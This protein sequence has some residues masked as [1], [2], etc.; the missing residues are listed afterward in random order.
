MAAALDQAAFF[1]AARLKLSLKNTD[2]GLRVMRGAQAVS[3]KRLERIGFVRFTPRLEAGSRVLI[4][5]AGPSATATAVAAVRGDFDATITLNA[6]WKAAPGAEVISYEFAFRDATKYALQMQ[7]IQMLD[8]T[9][10]VFKPHALMMMPRGERAALASRFLDVAVGNA[11]HFVPHNNVSSTYQAT[12]LG[13]LN[14]RRARLPIQWKGSLTMWL[15]LCWL[16]RVGT[17]GLIGTDL[18]TLQTGGSFVDHA[19]NTTSTSA[20]SLLSTLEKLYS[21]GYLADMAFRHFHT[22]TQLRAI[23]AE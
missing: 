13:L 23:L 16:S 12:S 14:R 10:I 22:N 9:C 15:D 8:P 7:E 11:A 6:A 17:V 2:L 21:H 3:M 18:G 4:V 20:P 1:W 19:T 5:G